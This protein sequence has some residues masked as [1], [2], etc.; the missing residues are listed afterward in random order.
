MEKSEVGVAEGDTTTSSADI[1]SPVLNRSPSPTT[2]RLY[3]DIEDGNPISQIGP[4]SQSLA[5]DLVG[6]SASSGS[7]VLYKLLKS[8]SADSAPS[9]SNSPERQASPPSVSGT[10]SPH[11]TEPKNIAHEK[12]DA[13]NTDANNSIPNNLSSTLPT[14]PETKHLTDLD[15][16][17]VEQNKSL[18]SNA[19]TQTLTVQNNDKSQAAK[20][21]PNNI[22]PSAGLKSAVTGS[23]ASSTPKLGTSITSRP[24]LGTPYPLPKSF[25]PAASSSATK[26]A[27]LD[28]KQAGS[29]PSASPLP[30]YGSSQVTPDA[31]QSTSKP[32]AA[33]L[34]TYSSTQGTL[35]KT[36]LP[37]S[38]TLTIK[39]TAPTPVASSS[40]VTSTAEQKVSKREAV[41]HDSSP[42]LANLGAKDPPK[43]NTE[44]TVDRI[45]TWTSVAEPGS[46]STAWVENANDDFSLTTE[47]VA[48]S[49]SRTKLA[50]S[51]KPDL[52]ESQLEHESVKATF[53]PAFDV[54]LHREKP[55]SS[56]LSL[57]TSGTTTSLYKALSPE[58]V[59]DIGEFTSPWWNEYCAEID[60]E[61]Q[62]EAFVDQLVAE[63]VNQDED[64][65]KL[66][67][68][69][70]DL[71][72]DCK[73]LVDQRK[74]YEGN[75][76]YAESEFIN[77]CSLIQQQWS[78]IEATKQLLEARRAKLDDEFRTKYAVF[79][80]KLAAVKNSFRTLCNRRRDMKA[81]QF[82]R[83]PEVQLQVGM[84]HY[85][86]NFRHINICA[87]FVI[88]QNQD[89]QKVLPK[90]VLDALADLV[91]LKS[92][93]APVEPKPNGQDANVE[94]RE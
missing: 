36:F 47:S 50:P 90:V 40:S 92:K 14:A 54:E 30:T 44:S 34:P 56:S 71:T 19:N 80:K 84:L 73:I 51:F 61:L 66:A 49:T 87:Q 76:N 62:N 18:A 68:E 75:A 78:R 59:D 2:R 79:F 65:A 29:K 12:A 57:G 91:Y 26:P 24:N 17:N 53:E 22:A 42:S 77:I 5:T 58:K 28:A 15:Q 31:K 37:T 86:E 89:P 21:E 11:N 93:F 81:F 33:P 85:D 48:N 32:L 1:K 69:L 13:P 94:P 46:S 6:Q 45:D 55:A 64:C 23:L 27:P 43:V 9:S 25:T 39:P 3:K 63:E 70:M 7:D 8:T 72:Q 82:I 35:A 67:Q 41:A 83:S 16:Q 88:E 4:V 52:K 38:S 60:Q 10:S 20:L 74:T